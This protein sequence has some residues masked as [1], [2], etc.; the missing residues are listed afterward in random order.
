LTAQYGQFVSIESVTIEPGKKQ[1]YVRWA[2]ICNFENGKDQIQFQFRER[3]QT[4]RRRFARSRAIT[5]AN[6]GSLRAEHDKETSFY[7]I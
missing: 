2:A 4:D 1:G 5:W 3:R 7:I 6:E